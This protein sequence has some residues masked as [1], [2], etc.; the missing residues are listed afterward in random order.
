MNRFLSGRRRWLVAI[1]ACCATVAAA[2]AAPVRP[3][4]TAVTVRVTPIAGLSTEVA[5]VAAAEEL[6]AFLASRRW[7]DPQAEPQEA[8]A[9][10]E[11]IAPDVPTTNPE[12]QNI[13][14]VGLITIRNQRTVL[15]AVPNVGIV[16]YVPG[17]ALPDGRVLVAVT[18]NSLTLKVEG[19][20]EEELMLFPS[21]SNDRRQP[22]G[23]GARGLDAEVLR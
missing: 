5:E 17:D 10:T 13:N 16:R 11:A 19:L 4:E 8:V 1:L 6:G 7:G 20:P 3:P 23:T 15:L 14:Y 22:D 9:S 18:D 21:I 12:L 2:L